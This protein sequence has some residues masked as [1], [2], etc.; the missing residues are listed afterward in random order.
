MY[1]VTLDQIIC[2]RQ[3]KAL[4]FS[5]HFGV[6]IQSGD[7]MHRPTAQDARSNNGGRL[8]LGVPWYARFW[9]HWDARDR[10]SSWASSIDRRNTF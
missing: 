4:V 5:R 2:R 7:D 3:L 9:P 8:L 10:L 6:R 1:L